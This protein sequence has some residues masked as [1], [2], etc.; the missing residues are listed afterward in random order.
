[1]ENISILIADYS[2]LV[3]VGIISLIDRLGY[4]TTY[5]EVNSL[6]K[7]EHL[8]NR[9][10]PF[11]MLVSTSFFQDKS[12]SF[13]RSTTN[14]FGRSR[15]ILIVDLPERNNIIP[16]FHDTIILTDVEKTIRRKIERQLL[17]LARKHESYTLTK[18]LS[19]REK[20]VLRYVALGYANK[21]I[22]EKLFISTHTVIA[23]RKNITLKV[24]IKTIAGLT[25]YA[26]IN[27]LI[28]IEEIEKR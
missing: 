21:E 20:D 4:Q 26:V 1:M 25:V 7:L 3:R 2:P 12:E 23:H 13:I 27:K 17:I 28:R 5:K 15:L 16:F 24:G 6:E 18:G 8:S 14:R 22:A 10:Q 9:V 19:D 11:L